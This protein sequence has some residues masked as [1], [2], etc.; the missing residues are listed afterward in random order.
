M[1]LKP[2]TVVYKYINHD[3]FRFEVCSMLVIMFFY[4]M[5]VNGLYE[6]YFQYIKKLFIFYIF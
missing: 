3:V 5:N 1:V 2:F 4:L 6:M